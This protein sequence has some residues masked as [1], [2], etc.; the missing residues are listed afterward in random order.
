MV[1]F[2]A[3]E[4]IK[5]VTGKEKQKD[6]CF[7]IGAS[8]QNYRVKEKKRDFDAN[9]AF[10]VSQKYGVST[11]WILTGKGPK[12][13]QDTCKQKSTQKKVSSLFEEIVQLQ[14]WLSEITAIEP[15]RRAWFKMEIV[16]KFPAYKKWLEEREAARK[17][18]QKAA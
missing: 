11:E 7:E 1:F 8:P 15:E 13:L 9:W 2:E 4:R 6:I 14:E 16:D 10:K 17:E 3:I 12:N 18:Q 5:S